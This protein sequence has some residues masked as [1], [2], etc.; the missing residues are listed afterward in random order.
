M[1][2]HQAGRDLVVRLRVWKIQRQTETAVPEENQTLWQMVQNRIWRTLGFVQT[3]VDKC[4]AIVVLL[5]A[6]PQV[7]IC[8]FQEAFLV[9]NTEES[10]PV[11]VG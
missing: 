9:G 5:E 11:E 10:E 4:A 7:R 2:R 6:V 1:K 8:D 3:G